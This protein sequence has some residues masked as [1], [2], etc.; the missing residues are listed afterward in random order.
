MSNLP[1]KRLYH[2]TSVD[3][4]IKILESGT[5]RL[6]NLTAMDD[7]EEAKSQ[8]SYNAGRWIFTSSW[9]TLKD[10]RK[11]F[12]LYGEDGK[13][14]CISLLNYPFYTIFG[15]PFQGNRQF[16]RSA[17]VEPFNYTRGIEKYI[18][19]Y[20]LVF[21]PSTIEQF[22]VEYTE[23]ED[24]KYPRISNRTDS[25]ISYF[26][27][28]LGKYKDLKWNYQKEIRYRLRPTM[29]NDVHSPVNEQ[30]YTQMMLN[31]IYTKISED[32]PIEYIDI[33]IKLRNLEIIFGSRV[34][35]SKKVEIENVANEYCPNPVF[36]N[37]NVN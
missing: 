16:M 35:S 24:L 27:G 30:D 7:P 14:V 8:D 19:E 12:K 20:N 10:D 5:L 22:N 25:G 9:T 34:D 29:M 21:Y 2:Y 31:T 18:E 17:H 36:F 23:D 6:N 15:N 1:I 13:G 33:P 26:D 37:S 4:L 32:C 11:M 28:Q 3:T